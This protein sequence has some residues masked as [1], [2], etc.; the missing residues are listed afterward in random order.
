MVGSIQFDDIHPAVC[1]DLN[2]QR[3]AF[4]YFIMIYTCTNNYKNTGCVGRNA[5][6]Y[7]PTYY[8]SHNGAVSSSDY[9][10]TKDG[11]TSRSRI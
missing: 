10:G 6:I 2:K 1:I 3:H 11:M 9:T 5:F 8:V 4:L 7:L